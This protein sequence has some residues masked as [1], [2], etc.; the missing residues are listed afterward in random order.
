MIQKGEVDEN[1]TE[2]GLH[3]DTNIEEE[4]IGTLDVLRSLDPTSI[5]KHGFSAWAGAA[6]LGIHL[7]TSFI[8]KMRGDWKRTALSQRSGSW[9]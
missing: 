8:V 7:L 1:T 5:Q 9:L 3:H 2:Y 6:T 4:V